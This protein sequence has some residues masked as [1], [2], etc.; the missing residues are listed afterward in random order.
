[1]T[2]FILISSLYIRDDRNE[3]LV[4]YLYG[5]QKIMHN[6]LNLLIEQNFNGDEAKKYLKKHIKEQKEGFYNSTGIKFDE[7]PYIRPEGTTAIVKDLIKK[8]NIE[9]NHKEL[10]FTA[11]DI[12]NMY[13]KYEHIGYYSEL[14]SNNK[15]QYKTKIRILNVLQTTSMTTSFCLV[16]LKLEKNKIQANKLFFE[17]RDQIISELNNT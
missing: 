11:F 16:F 1:L 17:I 9:K 4:K 15:T 14:I 2:D 3:Q 12:W 5:E 8:N 13:S 7:Y 10:I 6:H